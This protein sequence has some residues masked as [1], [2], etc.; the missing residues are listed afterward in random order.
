MVKAKANNIEIEFETFGEPSLKPLLLI[1]GLGTQMISWEEKFCEELV[2]RGF[3]VIRFDNRDVGLSTKFEDAGIPNIKEIMG[4]LQQGKKHVVPYTLE[5]MANDAIGLLDFLNIERA[6]ICGASMGGMIA[7][8]IAFRNPS[9][10]LSLTSMISS[11][12]NPNLP[13]A[14][15]EVLQLL[16][17]PL[18]KEREEYIEESLKRARI[19]YG[20]K[21]PFHEEEQR[22]LRARSYD[23]NFYPQGVARH[24]AA[25]LTNG[26]RK[27]KLATIKVPTLVI[28]GKND[29]LVPV[30][31]GIDTA[32]SILGAELLLIDGMG[33]NFPRE[34]WAQITD[35][36]AKNAAQADI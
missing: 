34:V 26:N 27:P 30:E 2:K 31:G 16:I 14:K 23:R 20:T 13:P 6:H 35:A 12:G 11:T 22:E 33:H 36:I 5:D 17:I 15:Q 28:H 9:R 7:Q 25:I 29:P 10:V 19:F 1:R 8:I 32:E 18:P 21:F 3:Y 4:G 24:L